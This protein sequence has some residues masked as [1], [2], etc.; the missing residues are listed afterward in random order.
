MCLGCLAAFSQAASAYD[1]GW[2]SSVVKWNLYDNGLLN[3][4]GTGLAYFGYYGVQSQYFEKITEIT[5]SEGIT[6]IIF[7]GENMPNLTKITLSSTCTRVDGTPY[8]SSKLEKY[9]VP[10]GNIAY[11]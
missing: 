9:V 10:S 2:I 3:F 5:L 6:G 11:K 7:E 4:S 8:N 1:W